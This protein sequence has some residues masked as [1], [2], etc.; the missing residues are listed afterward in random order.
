MTLRKKK[1]PF[2]QYQSTHFTP[3]RYGNPLTFILESTLPPLGIHKV[4]SFY[5]V[6]KQNPACIAFFKYG[7]KGQTSLYSV[8]VAYLLT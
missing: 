4:C 8:V 3:K 2:K 7:R 6:L 1:H 5:S